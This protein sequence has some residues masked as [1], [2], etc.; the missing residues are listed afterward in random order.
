M[1]ISLI[2]NSSH[3]DTYK[4]YFFTSLFQLFLNYI[5][6][7]IL[8]VISKSRKQIKS[9]TG[10]IELLYKQLLY[11]IIIKRCTY[12]FSSRI[13]SPLSLQKENGNTKFYS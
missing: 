1:F 2:I 4:T 3:H 12:K 6:T 11:L 5:F 9:I 7:N 13:N 8:I 10:K